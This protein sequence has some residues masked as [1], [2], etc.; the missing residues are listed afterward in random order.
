MK[1]PSPAA[2]LVAAYEAH[3]VP[4]VTINMTPHLPTPTMVTFVWR[5]KVWWNEYGPGVAFEHVY[6]VNALITALDWYSL[7]HL[8]AM[9]DMLAEAAGLVPPL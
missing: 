3:A 2:A 1:T 6:R 8:P 9:P 4:R 5:D 7:R